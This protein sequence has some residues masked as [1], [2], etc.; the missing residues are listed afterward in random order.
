MIMATG[1]EGLQVAEVQRQL[2][3]HW[4]T[5][6]A[7]TE[8]EE[9]DDIVSLQIGDAMIILGKMPAPI[10][11]SQLEGPCATS[12]LWRNAS[13]EV[14][15]HTIHWIVTV[16]AG[17]PP[18]ELSTLLTQATAAAL[19]ACPAAIG[20]YWGNATLIIPKHIFIDFAR[21][22]LPQGPPLHIWVDFRVGKNSD[23]TCAGFTAGMNALGHMEF[24]A[25]ESPE[26]PGELSRTVDGTGSLCCGERTSHPR[27]RHGGRRR[28]GAHSGRLQRFRI[29][30]Q[31]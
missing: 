6:S 25:L 9:T 14:K 27:W 12:I 15:Q 13:E 22:I 28:R 24:E 20:V 16:N 1:D 8:I 19:A 21:E 11:W 23:E 4:P 3:E 30:P 26:P 18:V 2:T 5:L 31:R 17:L 7:A 10:P 29:W